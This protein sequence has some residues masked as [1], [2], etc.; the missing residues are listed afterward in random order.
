MPARR[1]RGPVQAGGQ[2]NALV[3]TPQQRA[4]LDALTAAG[5]QPSSE[6]VAL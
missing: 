2:S 1:L 4:Y 5:V 3:V 6:L